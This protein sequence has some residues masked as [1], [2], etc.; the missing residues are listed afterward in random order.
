MAVL[1]PDAKVRPPAM[2]HDDLDV[3]AA[4]AAFYRAFADRDPEAM[5][6][7]WARRD[8][9][10]CVHPGWQALHGR[11]EV[12]ASW[13]SILESPDAPEISCARAM[14]YAGAE[15]AFVVCVERL[16]GGTLAATNVFVRESG[17]W[18]IVHHHAGPIAPDRA[19]DDG[20][21]EPP[22]LLN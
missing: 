9:V 1:T 7:L 6:A 21:D 11:D 19:A 13:R 3:L 18:R 15:F 17:E 10:A 22:S 12:M 20:D 2:P 8:A 4:N 5:D 16:Q 14:V